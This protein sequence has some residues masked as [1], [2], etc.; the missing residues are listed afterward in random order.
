MKMSMVP[1][2]WNNSF[3][4]KTMRG[5]KTQNCMF[6]SGVFT[7]S[8]MATMSPSCNS[9]VHI[10][11][12]FLLFSRQVMSNSLW[13]RGLQPTRLLCPWDSPGKNAGV[14]CHFL[15]KGVFLIQGSNGHL[16]HWQADSLPLSH[17]ESPISCLPIWDK[18]PSLIYNSPFNI[19]HHGD[20]LYSKALDL[21]LQSTSTTY[22][23][24][25]PLNW[26]SL[27]TTPVLGA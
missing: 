27:R 20:L 22:P 16:L 2:D 4:E 24:A 1:W 7:Y 5:I 11:L 17:Q 12:R 6:T 14:G 10:I 8:P 26:S 25:I 19:S 21:D 13:P 9:F 18:P 3:S 23:K 15:L